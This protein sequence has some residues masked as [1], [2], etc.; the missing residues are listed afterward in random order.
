MHWLERK[1]VKDTQATE[2][3]WESD[4]MLE[5]TDKNFKGAIINVVKD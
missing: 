4:Q 5:L 2:N 1:E 3:A